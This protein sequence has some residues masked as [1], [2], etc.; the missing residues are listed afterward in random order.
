MRFKLMIGLVV[1]VISVLDVHAHG[2]C[3]PVALGQLEFSDLFQDPQGLASVGEFAFVGAEELGVLV[4]NISDPANPLVVATIDTAGS[5]RALAIESNKLYV[6]DGSAGLS[7]FDIDDPTNASL[8][9]SLA[10]IGADDLVGIAIDGS[11]AYVIDAQTGLR[12]IDVSDAT[13]PTQIGQDPDVPNAQIRAARVKL[14]GDTAV[15]SYQRFHPDGVP[16]VRLL[17]ITNPASPVPVGWVPVPGEPSG[18]ALRDDTLFI[19]DFLGAMLMSFDASDASSPIPL[20]V[21]PYN[22]I[23]DLS[24]KGGE[25]YVLTRNS[26]LQLVDAINAATL[27]EL[28]SIATQSNAVCVDVNGAHAMVLDGGLS[29]PFDRAAHFSLMDVGSCQLQCAADFTSDG[30]LDIFD[31]FA[32][33]DA[34]NRGDPAA[35]FTADGSLD[36]FDVFA[37]LDAFADG[38][39]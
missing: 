25:L 33:I 16:G 17:N 20:D 22:Q 13:Q 7:I 11:T 26:G 9:G 29:V 5:A 24:V 23:V 32:F 21:T 27:T 8:L 35:D 30:L 34:F 12:A 19:A 18:I 1:L 28:G 37:Y 2:Q 15:V 36:V 39:P 10:G 31:V 14:S 4:I 38:C 3:D 6:A